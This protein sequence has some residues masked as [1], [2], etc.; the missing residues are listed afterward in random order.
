MKCVLEANVI[1]KC[2]L[3]DSDNEA[4]TL[5]APSLMGP[6]LSTLPPRI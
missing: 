3:R 1:V 5:A 2:L 4:D 6:L